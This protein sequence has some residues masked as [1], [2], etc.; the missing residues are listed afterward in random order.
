M[1]PQIPHQHRELPVTEQESWGAFSK[2]EGSQ[3]TTDRRSVS[4][5]YQLNP[6]RPGCGGPSPRPEG[7]RI[8]QHDN[9][10]VRQ[11]VGLAP[12]A[13]RVQE[14]TALALRVQEQGRMELA[15]TVQEQQ[16]VQSSRVKEHAE[17]QSRLSVAFTD[18]EA[19]GRSAQM[20]VPKGSDL[21]QEAL[22]R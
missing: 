12:Q 5:L 10:G 18:A 15:L 21:F 1:C 20:N 8:W 4:P 9:A 14:Q 13:T 19:M 2:R 11:Q 7:P 22:D 3:R 6:H 16:L 17:Q